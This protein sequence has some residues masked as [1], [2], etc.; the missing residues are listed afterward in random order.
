MTV[1][2]LI[3]LLTTL[4]ADQVVY[5]PGDESGDFPIV[6]ASVDRLKGSDTMAVMLD[7]GVPDYE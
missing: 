6:G 4:P 1:A 5:M 3:A 7:A 2:Q